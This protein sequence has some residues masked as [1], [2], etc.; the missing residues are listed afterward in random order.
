MNNKKILVVDDEELLRDML[1]E[2]LAGEGYQVD[3]AGNGI[4]A[5]E[6]IMLNDY[7]LVATDFFMPKM[8]GL[9]LVKTCQDSFSNV[10][11]ILF[12]GGGK[13]LEINVNENCIA[14]KGQKISVDLY[15]KKPFSIDDVLVSIESLF[16]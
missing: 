15:I 3:S 16:S 8:N 1:V 11:F 4:E 14:Y 6:L 10:K 2:V 9:E 12:S 7:D 5:S 13:E